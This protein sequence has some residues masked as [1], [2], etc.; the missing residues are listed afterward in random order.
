[1]SYVPLL[2]R[3]V[4]N[5]RLRDGIWSIVSIGPFG[6]RVR[7]GPLRWSRVKVGFTKLKVE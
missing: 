6:L 2:I 4:P 7:D 5:K 3:H 1:M